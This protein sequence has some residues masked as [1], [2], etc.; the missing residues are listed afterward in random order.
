MSGATTTTHTGGSLRTP[1]CADCAPCL[2]ASHPTAV[3][4][5]AHPAEIN[6][7]DLADTPS[8]LATILP[9]EHPP[10]HINPQIVGDLIVPSLPSDLADNANRALRLREE[11]DADEERTIREVETWLG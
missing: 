1:P 11:A 8:I 7:N 5:S 4:P 3:D 9:V 6:I 10:T 2:C